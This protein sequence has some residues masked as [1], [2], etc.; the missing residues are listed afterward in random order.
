MTILCLFFLNFSRVYLIRSTAIIGH[1]RGKK[2]PQFKTERIIILVLYWVAAMLD[3]KN[4]KKL[5]KSALGISSTVDFKC[6]AGLKV[7]EKSK[8]LPKTVTYKNNNI[9]RVEI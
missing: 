7:L 8:F 2:C 5:P 3:G 9:V 6:I 4:G 1:S